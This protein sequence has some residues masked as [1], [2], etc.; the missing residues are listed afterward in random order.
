MICTT[1]ILRLLVGLLLLQC[2]ASLEGVEPE[3]SGVDVEPRQEDVDLSAEE[4]MTGPGAEK[5]VSDLDL[6]KDGKVSFSELHARMERLRKLEID[7]HKKEEEENPDD[8][9]MPT[10]K[11][12]MEDP[13]VETDFAAADVNKDGKLDPEE[14]YMHLYPPSEGQDVYEADALKEEAR[15]R[16]LASDGNGDGSLSTNEFALFRGKS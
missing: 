11:E 7:L 13:A 4:D 8:D 3:E 9:Q 1:Y 5:I 10:D 14:T 16:F 15:L 6:D 12:L 2:A